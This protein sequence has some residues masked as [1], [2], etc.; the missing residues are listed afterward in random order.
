MNDV[1]PELLTL[2]ITHDS[3]LALVLYLCWFIIMP[4]VKYVGALP[5][6]ILNMW[7]SINCST[8]YSIGSSDC[9]I[10]SQ[11]FVTMQTFVQV[12]PSKAHREIGLRM[13]SHKTCS[14]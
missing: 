9:I 6:I 13:S 7:P 10:V 1:S 8:L 14:A 3:S 4:D 2:G 11:H 12:A 5:F